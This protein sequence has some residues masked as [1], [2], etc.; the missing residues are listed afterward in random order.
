MARIDPL[1]ETLPAEP[2]PEDFQIYRHLV[3]SFVEQTRHE[4]LP[5]WSSVLL[6]AQSLGP[7]YAAWKRA[8]IKTAPKLIRMAREC[9][10]KLSPP[11][12]W[13]DAKLRA[14]SKIAPPK[15]LALPWVAPSLP[16]WPLSG[17]WKSLSA[18]PK[19]LM[20][21]RFRATPPSVAALLSFGV[22]ACCLPK[23][24]GGYENAYRRRRFKLAAI[25][26]PVMAA[27]HPSPWLI[28]NTDPLAKAGESLAAVRREVRR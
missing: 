21:I 4:A 15:L 17:N 11:P 28:Q 25:P 14:L 5:Y 23:K 27:F 7:R 26:G 24:Q 10:N 12:A 2:A 19:L 16:W 3:E 20:F 8:H 6:P 13:P 1:A 18:D 22:E 9:R